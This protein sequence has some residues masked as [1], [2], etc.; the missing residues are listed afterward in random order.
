MTARE[1]DKAAKRL[2]LMRTQ[3]RSR[4]LLSVPAAALAGAAFVVSDAL[5]ISIAV[6]AA[7]LLVLALVDTT[8][9]RR[10]LAN[11]ARNEHA[12]VVPDVKR[13]GEALVMPRG[14]HRAAAALE[15]VL[16]NAGTPG[17]YYLAGRVNACRHEIRAL[18]D[19]LRA[20]GTRAE[21]TSLALCWELLR[22]GA[23]SPLYNWH[24]PAE[25]LLVAVRRIRAGVR[26]A[27]AAHG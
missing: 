3:R 10:L 14:R 12:Y 23:D 4:L 17:S 16:K 20:P 22:D 27:H 24:I 19:A 15:R 7:A 2:E 6:G 11:L 26:R 8:R 1:V 18:A 25:D 9:R 5:A 21:P 13:Y